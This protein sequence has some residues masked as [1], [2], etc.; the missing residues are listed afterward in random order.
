MCL[1]LSVVFD[2]FLCAGCAF[3]TFSTK[4]SAQ[5]AIKAVHQSTTMEVSES[6][7]KSKK[8]KTTVLFLRNCIPYPSS[9]NSINFSSKNDTNKLKQNLSRTFIARLHC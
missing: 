2:S 6:K 8:L 7:T 1:M 3:V 4:Q 9:L 5:N